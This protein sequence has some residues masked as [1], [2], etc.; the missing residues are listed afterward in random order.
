M[1]RKTILFLVALTAVLTVA[2]G[3]AVSE[4][5]NVELERLGNKLVIHLAV[6][7][8][9]TP[10]LKYD[11][12]ARIMTM[13]LKGTDLA[14]DGTL[15]L[16][17]SDSDKLW[18]SAVSFAEEDGATVVTFAL[19]E[20]ANP[21]DFIV[22]NGVNEVLAVI[23]TDGSSGFGTS[24]A[25]FV[26]SPSNRIVEAD[27]SEGI[28]IPDDSTGGEKTT[29]DP[30]P[31]TTE[32]ETV[33]A[34]EDATATVEA[35]EDAS[36]PVV[37]DGVTNENTNESVATEVEVEAPGAN[38]DGIS[39]SGAPATLPSVPS[40]VSIYNLPHPPLFLESEDGSLYENLFGT[41]GNRSDAGDESFRYGSKRQE[42][43]ISLTVDEMP[44]GLVI[45]SLIDATDYNVIIS[46]AVADKVV[47]SLTLDKISLF[48][49]LDLL[50][51]SYN[52]SYVVEHN[53][54]VVGEKDTLE[55]NFDKLITKTFWLDYADGLSVMNVLTKMGLAREGNVQVYNGE[56]ELLKVNG[57]SSLSE[58]AGDTVTAS[59][60]DIKKMPSL[61]ST[62]RRNMIVVTE[63]EERMTRIAQV[64]VDLD[65]KP[66][67]IR[68]ETEIIEI[69][70]TGTKKLGLELSDSLGNP[71]LTSGFGEAIPPDSLVSGQVSSFKLQTFVR[72]P[73]EFMV[74]LHH[75]ID[76]DEGKMLAKPNMTAI[77]GTQAIYFAGQEVP[78]ISSPAQS[79]G[80]TFTPATVEFKTVGITLNFKPRI[81][82]DGNI[83]IEVNPQVSTLVGF[84]DLGSGA[85]APQTQTR[86]ATATVRVKSGDV[87]VL[88][89]MIS[90]EE[91]ESF[92]R[93]PFLHKL[94]L[95]GQLFETKS[96]KKEK[97]EIVVILRPFIED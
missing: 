2:A 90:E 7:G 30:M 56:I 50:T 29:V 42:P 72:D 26:P 25:E 44:L 49:A 15:N 69:S 51:R 89:G 55:A 20:S 14:S 53:T 94:P 17:L 34:E 96:T 58:V 40:V 52:L 73:L 48:A 59:S 1:Y 81:D 5:K 77:D 9:V 41:G 61:I 28:V 24:S 83:T 36:V 6:G 27:L 23:Y 32:T 84:I 18:L 38:A 35:V 86:Q 19:G 93:I 22:R 33:V 37:D 13:T 95:F 4:M 3:Y 79:Q 87:L 16:P 67:Q 85:K 64:I 57:A 47:S 45:A 62:A 82:R 80:A 76:E 68:L 8:G 78:Y 12:S 66:K 97:T 91:R 11:E 10:I 60:K 71:I 46:D 75:L 39:L 21:Y 70:E 65:R 54:I 92:S 88:G 43:T 31:E 63:T 74:S